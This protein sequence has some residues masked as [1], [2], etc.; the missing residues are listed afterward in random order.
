MVERLVTVGVYGFT[1]EQFLATLESSG[2][3][4]LLDVRQRRGVRGTE[5]AWANSQ[6]LQRAMMDHGIDYRHFRELAPTSEI[7]ALQY[8]ADAASGQGKRTRTEL[9]DAFK[10]AYVERILDAVDLQALFASVDPSATV[11]LLCVE[12]D[13]RA[14]HRSLIADRLS[15]EQQVP[16]AHLMP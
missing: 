5:Y 16:I 13:A 15:T 7:R 2:V 10:R 12:R 6:R 4:V 9:S 14:C 1:A 11:A 3:D 8:A